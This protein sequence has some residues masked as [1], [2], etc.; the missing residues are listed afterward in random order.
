MVA[1]TLAVPS[2]LVGLYEAPRTGAGLVDRVEFHARAAYNFAVN[3]T[4]ASAEDIGKVVGAAAF[5]EA[6]VGA[7]AHEVLNLLPGASYKKPP[8][9]ELV[10]PPRN[11]ITTLRDS[12]DYPADPILSSQSQERPPLL[13]QPQN[14]R[15]WYRV[16]G[17]VRRVGRFGF[18]ARGGF[19]MFQPRR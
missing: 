11:D 15:A 9:A 18:V 1:A 2:A 12:K 4:P 7:C 13:I 19:G 6:L 3:G 10:S 5:C 17:P 8:R 16:P 14:C